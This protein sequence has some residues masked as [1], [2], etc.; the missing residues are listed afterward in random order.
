[1]TTWRRLL[2]GLAAHTGN[3]Q[4]RK[5]RLDPEAWALELEES[6]RQVA[7]FPIVFSDFMDALATDFAAKGRAPSLP[8]FVFAITEAS[9]A[10]ER[11]FVDGIAPALRRLRHARLLFVVSL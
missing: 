1:M 3:I 9:L 8:V 5:G 6:A 11:Y 7:D 10:P 4:D 2:G